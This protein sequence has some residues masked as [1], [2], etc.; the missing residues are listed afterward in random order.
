VLWSRFA[1]VLVLM[2]K[3]WGKLDLTIV[4]WLRFA[5]VLVLM[6]KGWGREAAGWRKSLMTFSTID[7]VNFSFKRH[8]VTDE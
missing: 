6:L 8:Q 3:D 4:L 2:L 1:A 7:R 5:V